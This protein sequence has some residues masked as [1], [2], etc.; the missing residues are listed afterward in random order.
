MKCK[1]CGTYISRKESVC[2]NCGE[3]RRKN[4]YN[5]WGWLSVLVLIALV[6]IAMILRKKDDAPEK[7]SNINFLPETG[8]VM[9]EFNTE[10]INTDEATGISYVDNILIVYF[11]EEPSEEEITAV[12]QL[13]Q[14][15]MVGTIGGIHQFQFEVESSEYSEM[16]SLAEKVMALPY[17]EDASPDIAFNL[18]G[19]IIPNDPWKKI[20]FWKEKWNTDVPSGSNW[21]QEAIN[22]PEAWENGNFENITIGV[23]D[24]GI[25][26]SHE[27]LCEKSIVVSVNNK[28]EIEQHG[29][30]VIGIIG[31]TA[32]NSLGINGIVWDCDFVCFDWELSDKQKESGNYSG[33]TSIAHQTEAIKQL[34]LNGAKVINFSVGS[35]EPL[36]SEELIN[37]VGEVY[38]RMI[39]EYLECGFDFLFVQSAG[40]DS[41]DSKKNALFCSI[42]NDNCTTTDRVSVSDVMNHIIIVGAA[43]NKGN[44]KY[45]MSSFSNYGSGI[46]ICAPGEDIYSTVRGGYENMS[47]T[48]MAAPIVT[49]VA[50]LAWSANPQLTGADVKKIVCNT[51]NTKYEV[52][53]MNDDNCYRMVNAELVVKEACSY[54]KQATTKQESSIFQAYINEE[55]VK[56]YGR[57]NAGEYNLLAEVDLDW[58]TSYAF[59]EN[60]KGILNTVEIDVDNDG[61]NELVVLRLVN[62]LNN[63]DAV[64]DL[65]KCSNNQIEQCGSYTYEEIFKGDER[66]KISFSIVKND[67]SCYFCIEN[68]YFADYFG[69][70][71][72]GDN[73]E[74]F[75]F[76]DYVLNPVVWSRRGGMYNGYGNDTIR[77]R[78]DL[79]NLGLTNSAECLK[80]VIEDGVACLYEINGEMGKCDGKKGVIN[81]S[82]KDDVTA[83]SKSEYFGDG[84]KV[85]FI[86][87]DILADWSEK[88]PDLIY[89]VNIQLLQDACAEY[90][91]WGMDEIHVILDENS[92]TIADKCFSFNGTVVEAG[93]EVYFTLREGDDYMPEIF[94]SDE[95]VGIPPLDISENPCRV[96]VDNMGVLFDEGIQTAALDYLELYLNEY[97]NFYLDNGTNYIAEYVEG[98]FVPDLNFPTFH[99]YIEELDLDIQC[100]YITSK[101]YYRFTSR[102]NPNGE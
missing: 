89:D 84:T 13:V 70:T 12:E 4:Y 69:V 27:D 5:H 90:K 39:C 14:G 79:Y 98:T 50:A 71:G 77:Y 61:E 24:D 35:K 75:E 29:T 26:L 63:A 51:S 100:V 56:K 38:S 83:H 43:K 93:L 20:L 78:K 32:N 3:K 97:F 1:K 88:Y 95:S 46:D 58:K 8:D 25:D 49:G 64:I 2:P 54:K 72:G 10:R 65:Y 36:E 86:S 30:H 81:C 80:L 74:I 94:I 66:M 102:F 76:D 7:D 82:L 15:N 19:N 22:M 9:Y 59:E 67:Y 92:L 87:Y 18:E 57:V 33:W 73:I 40:N 91:N 31:A 55:L 34:L 53:R 85:S 101:E 48:S 52:P 11:Y 21:W 17:V 96:M 68:D 37:K 6:I 28:C 47:G 62:S 60:A 16:L 41:V 99:I 45:E 42:T 23:Y 44:C